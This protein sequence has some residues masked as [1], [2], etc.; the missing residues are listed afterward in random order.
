[1]RP[2]IRFIR[3]GRLVELVDVPPTMML[4]DYLRENEGSTGTK[5]GCAE[6]DCGAC[7]IALGRLRNGKLIYEPI[8]ACIQLLGQID[9]TEVVTVE[10]LVAERRPASPGAACHGREPRFAV[11]LLHAGL[12]HGDLRALPGRPTAR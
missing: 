10:D 1:M 4:L 3:R 8:N 11:R 9:G 7:T 2:T 6:G 12:R 5:E